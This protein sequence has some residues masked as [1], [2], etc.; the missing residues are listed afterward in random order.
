MP[1]LAAL[2]RGL[3][4][5]SLLV[6]AIGCGRDVPEA[7][8]SGI[9][10]ILVGSRDDLGYN[11]A[12]WEGKE[13]LARAYPDRKVSAIENVPESDA[14]VDALESLIDDGASI[15]F[16]TSFGHLAAARKVAERHPEVVVVHQ[17][18]VESEPRLDNLGTYFGQHA[19]AVYAA[20]IAAGAATQSGEIGLVA[21]FPIPA[22]RN[23]ANALLLG[24][25]RVRPDA[26]VRVVFTDDWCDPDAQRRA[27]AALLAEGADVLAQHQDCT[28]VVLA[29]AEETGVAAIGYHA[30][31]SEV[32][33]TAW[34]TGA[35][36]TWDDL[37]VDIVATV[38]RGDFAS[39]PYN[40]D[41]RGTL[42]ARD[43]PIALA[44]AGPRV[45]PTTLELI[46]SALDA[47]GT[48]AA[49]VFDGPLQ[50]TDGITRVPAGARMTNAQEDG[51]DFF[52]DGVSV[53]QPVIGQRSLGSRGRPRS[54][55]A[56]M[57]E[58]TSVVPPP[59][60]RARL[61]R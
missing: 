48:G 54:C 24:A 14:A 43:N 7:E 49:T 60:V 37:F 34:L 1:T 9:G 31:G 30:D 53:L 59:M 8:P 51:M 50:D 2:V 19:E 5:S 61:N 21:A 55:S 41:F 45:A 28:R 23:N 27:A 33:P 29:A 18:G 40:G 4:L 52:V 3:V 12:V 11:Q 36:W 15:L 56:M 20:G 26:V 47:F 44:E 35:I 17:G 22:T 10:F 58:S 57:F 39:S 16:A 6:A 25:R 38:T 42:V 13:R 46:E 32:A